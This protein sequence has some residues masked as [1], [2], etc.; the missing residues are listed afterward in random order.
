MIVLVGSMSD[1]DAGGVIFSNGNLWQ[2]NRRFT[3][4]SLR[5]LGF[6]K[7]SMEELIGEEVIEFISHVKKKNGQPAE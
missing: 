3:L 6:G 5:N 4:H 7:G 2:S 1:N